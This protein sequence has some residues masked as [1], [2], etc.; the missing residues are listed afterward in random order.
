M[1]NGHTGGS[2]E[3]HLLP[4][5]DCNTQREAIQVS[6]AKNCIGECTIPESTSGYLVMAKV[7]HAYI[8]LIQHEHTSAHAHRTDPRVALGA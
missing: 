3:N 5:I 7:M 6:R 4:N 8:F 1:L 2:G